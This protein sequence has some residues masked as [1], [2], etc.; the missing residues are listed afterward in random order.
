MVFDPND[1]WNFTYMLPKLSPDEPTHLLIPSCL[2]MGWC[3]STSYFC[4]S[5]KTACNVGTTL[6]CNPIRSLLAH[7]LEHH[8]MPTDPDQDTHDDTQHRNIHDTNSIKKFLHLIEVDI[9]NFI[10]LTQATDPTQKKLLHLSH[11]LLHTIHSVFPPP[12]ITGGSKEDPM[13][14]KKLLHGDGLWAMCK[15]ILGW[16]FNGVK[17]G[18]KLPNSKHKCIQLELCTK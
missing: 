13:A 9:D 5:S 1:K 10:Q 15:E 8:L 16:I 3:E 18:I 2:Q 6:T 14:L 12:S 11:A 7:P 4:A 17:C